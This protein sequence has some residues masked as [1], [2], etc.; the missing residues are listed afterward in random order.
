MA[1]V[2]DPLCLGPV[3]LPR[4][5][6]WELRSRHGATYRVHV[7]WPAEA[8]PAAGFP[9]ICQ[10]DGD[11]TFATTVE[12]IRTRAHRTDAT[13][14]VPSIVVGVGSDARSEDF[15]DEAGRARF[16]TFLTDEL[17]PAIA[18]RFAVDPAR[19]ALIGHSLGGLFVLETL[20]ETPLM[21][22]G[23]FSTYVAISPSIWRGGEALWQRVRDFRLTAGSLPP[24]LLITVGEYEQRLAPWQEGQ[25]NA[26]ELLARREARQMVDQAQRFA[27]ALAAVA[28][29]MA[30]HY[31]LLTGEDHASAVLRSMGDALRLTSAPP[32]AVLMAE[33]PWLN[34]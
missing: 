34:P 16:L 21:P 10:L 11:A 22:L 33:G 1:R 7:A 23:P 17:L 4:S 27:E 20:L 14:V 29:D 28:P 30:V 5:E 26:A 15:A 13:A 24:R 18:R 25:P 3:T 2:A 9:V 6:R 32:G 31:R 12:S 8:P 19:R